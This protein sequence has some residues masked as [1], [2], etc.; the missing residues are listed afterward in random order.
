MSVEGP[1]KVFFQGKVAE[2]VAVCGISASLDPGGLWSGQNYEN[3][4]STL[5]R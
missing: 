1:D 5:D 2:D 3:K 4:Y